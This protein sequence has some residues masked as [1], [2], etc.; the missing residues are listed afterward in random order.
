M[1][2][3]GVGVGSGL[4]LKAVIVGVCA[5][6]MGSGQWELAMPIP[7]AV[8]A[9]REMQSFGKPSC[10]TASIPFRLTVHVT[11]NRTGPLECMSRCKLCFGE[12]QSSQKNHLKPIACGASKTAKQFH[13]SRFGQGS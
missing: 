9:K 2:T 1:E 7:A 6:G 5:V 11:R 13:T 3:G 12:V 4:C 10:P 8:N